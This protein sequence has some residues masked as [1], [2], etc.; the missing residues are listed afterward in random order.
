LFLEIQDSSNATAHGPEGASGACC[1]LC[2]S[3]SILL[4]AT[5]YTPYANEFA[6]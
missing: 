4:E 1:A 2:V 6:Y 3:S 5:C